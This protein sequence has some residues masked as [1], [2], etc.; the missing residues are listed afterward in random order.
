MRQG[1]AGQPE[2]CLDPDVECLVER[3]LVERV[4]PRDWHVRGIVQ[5]DVEP[6]ELRDAAI[7]Q[8]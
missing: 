7:D 4:E 2:R 1:I 5:H 6:A 8:R 3:R